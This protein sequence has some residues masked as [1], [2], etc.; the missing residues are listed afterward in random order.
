MT[1]H[2]FWTYKGKQIQTLP[3]PPERRV[4]ATLGLL[5]FIEKARQHKP[6][7]AAE[8]AGG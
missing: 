3:V 5:P 2:L 7:P 8:L 1:T 4:I 6:Q